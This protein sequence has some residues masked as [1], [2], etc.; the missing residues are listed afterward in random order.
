MHP[1]NENNIDGYLPDSILLHEAGDVELLAE[2][3]KRYEFGIVV[4]GKNTIPATI[5]HQTGQ[6]IPGQSELAK[7]IWGETIYLASV[8]RAFATWAEGRVYSHMFDHEAYFPDIG[9]EDYDDGED[10]EDGPDDDSGSDSNFRYGGAEGE[11][12]EGDEAII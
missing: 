11:E 7:D 1:T 9:D 4:L 2:F 3:R 6:F 10:D 8:L 5:D 12:E